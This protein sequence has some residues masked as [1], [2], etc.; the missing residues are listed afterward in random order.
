MYVIVLESFRENEFP[1]Y[2]NI[3]RDTWTPNIKHATKIK[4]QG[5]A[6]IL[7]DVLSFSNYCKVEKIEGK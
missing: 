6:N 1:L 3:E 4:V 5:Y 2:Y 7:R